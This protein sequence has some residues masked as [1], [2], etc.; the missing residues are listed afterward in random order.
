MAEQ[1][2]KA[3]AYEQD[4]LV[5]L[6]RE[7]L[8][9]SEADAAARAEDEALALSLGDLLQDSNG[10]VVLFNNSGL[11]VLMLNAEAGVVEEGHSGPHVTAGGDDVSGFRFVSFDNGMTLF[12]QGGLDLIVR[13]EQS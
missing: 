1:S 5:T 12:Y 8:A 9:G 7:L 11:P 2:G 10:E 13:S 3:V 4:D 6:G